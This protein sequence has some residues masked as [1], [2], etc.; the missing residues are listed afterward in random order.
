M[1][2]KG[3]RS[4]DDEIQRRQLSSALSRLVCHRS[5]LQKCIA[6]SSTSCQVPAMHWTGLK[7]KI[8]VG[9]TQASR[10]RVRKGEQFASIGAARRNSIG[11]DRRNSEEGQYR[12]AIEIETIGGPHGPGRYEGLGRTRSRELR[13]V[14]SLWKLMYAL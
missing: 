10:N 12:A 3:R 9:V 8:I 2:G 14:V 6:P 13:N 7:S 4:F 11:A 1:A 5:S